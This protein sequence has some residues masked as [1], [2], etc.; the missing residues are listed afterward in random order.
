[1]GCCPDSFHLHDKDEHSGGGNHKHV[2][3]AED[4]NDDG[5]ICGKHVGK[6][7]DVHVHTDNNAA[8]G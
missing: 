8:K 4:F 5:W 3:N 7:G 1:M 2:G 6:N